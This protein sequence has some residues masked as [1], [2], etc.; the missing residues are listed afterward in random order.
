MKQCLPLVVDSVTTV[1]NIK[2]FFW[3]RETVTGAVKY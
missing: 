3:T 2:L 1:V